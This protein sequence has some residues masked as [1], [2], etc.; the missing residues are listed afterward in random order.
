MQSI[1]CLPRMPKTQQRWETELH[2]AGG[3]LTQ[4]QT[5]GGW[6]WQLLCQLAFGNTYSSATLSAMIS[7][8]DIVLAAIKMLSNS[9]TAED[10]N[11]VMETRHNNITC[12]TNNNQ[13]N[14]VF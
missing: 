3:R 13:L 14:Y 7:S 10:L 6:S 12:T 9:L 1:V 8:L 11:A 4:W 2:I 5:C